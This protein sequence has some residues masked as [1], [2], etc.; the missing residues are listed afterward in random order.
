MTKNEPWSW[1]NENTRAF[2]ARGYL[3]E[4]QT[5]EERV[6]VIAEHAEKILGQK[7]F[8]EKFEKYMRD[9]KSVV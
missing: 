9:R 2:M 5:T 3:V 6:H 7:G 1:I 4:G 8:A